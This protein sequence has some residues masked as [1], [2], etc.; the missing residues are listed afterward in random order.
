MLVVSD[1]AGGRHDPAQFFRRGRMVPHPERAARHAVLHA[2]CVEHGHTVIGPRARDLGP[3]LAVHSPDYV[4]FLGSAWSR[5]GEIDADLEELLTTQFTGRS[6]SASPQSLAAAL[7]YFACDTSTAIRDGTWEAASSAAFCAATAA[8][9]A[10]EAGVAYALARP[11]GHHASADCAGGFCYLNNT[12]I[13]AQRLLDKGAERVAILDIDVHHGN[14]AQRIFYARS[15]VLTVS[16]HADPTAY[17]P[18]YSGFA[19]ERGAGAGEGFNRNL[20]LA[21]GAAD[22]VFLDAVSRSLDEIA[23]FSPSAL[24][25]A[26][27]LDAAKEDPVGVFEVTTD[28]FSACAARI[29][30][31]GWPTVLVQEGGYLCEALPRNLSAFLAAFEDRMGAASRR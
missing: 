29:A 5:R 21:H 2:A 15:D 16:V 4:A 3:I 7:G 23:R 31:G 11:P 8:E 28:G 22:R 19:G 14:G 1:P 6:P 20:P 25:V 17:F 13:A 10:L 30:Q 26:L 27:G 24:V 9:A 12:A 18:L